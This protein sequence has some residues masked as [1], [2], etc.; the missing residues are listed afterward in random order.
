MSEV[1]TKEFSKKQ[2]KMIAK[3]LGGYP[4]GLSGAGAANPGDVRTYEWLVECKTHT[5]PDHSILFDLDVWKKIQQE[6]FGFQRK[7]VLIVDD[8]SQ[9]ID[10]TWCLCR[11][12]NLNLSGVI[13]VSLPMSVRKNI[14]CRHE[15]LEKGLKEAIKGKIEENTFFYNCQVVY[16]TEW[17]GKDVTVMPFKVF[18]ELFDK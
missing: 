17:A 12:D 13:A 11:S 2:E 4:V 16:E 1:N 18:K 9:S 5:S 14:T 7:P 10:K 15:K 8:G 6:A 3:E